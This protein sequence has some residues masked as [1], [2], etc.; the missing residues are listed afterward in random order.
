MS[1][2]MFPLSRPIAAVLLSVV[3]MTP[4]A[5]A[6]TP[7]AEKPPASSRP[8]GAA[9]APAAAATAAP[10]LPARQA[11]LPRTAARRFDSTNDPFEVSPQLREGRTGN[12]YQSGGGASVLELNRFIRLKAVLLIRGHSAA[13]LQI[14]NQETITV[15][16]KE[17]IDLGDLGTYQVTIDHDGVALANPGLPQGRKVLR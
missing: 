14:R 10:G 8:A 4:A 17:L 1:S 9:A 16:D 12:R 2:L 7:A 11:L 6:Q 3:V 13:Q 15:M 5:Q